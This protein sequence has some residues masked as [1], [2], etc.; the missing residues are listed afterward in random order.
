MKIYTYYPLPTFLIFSDA[1]ARSFKVE[2]HWH[3]PASAVVFDAFKE[4]VT[5]LKK[6]GLANENH[7]IELAR[8]ASVLRSKKRISLQSR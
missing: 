1:F 2:G 3:K 8:R 6:Q 7:N 5:E 4:A